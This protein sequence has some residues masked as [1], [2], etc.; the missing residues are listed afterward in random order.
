MASSMLYSV[1]IIC[2]VICFWP[3]DAYGENDPAVVTPNR[4]EICSALA[5]AMSGNDISVMKGVRSRHLSGKV[6]SSV[7]PYIP[8]LS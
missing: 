8:I 2:M 5:G 7:P 4:V 3:S 1:S 6:V